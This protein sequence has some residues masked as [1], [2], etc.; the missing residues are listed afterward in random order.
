[1]K[2]DDLIKRATPKSEALLIVPGMDF[3]A[4]VPIEH[5]ELSISDFDW[6]S[7]LKYYGAPLKGVI[8]GD[9]KK[10]YKKGYVVRPLHE[11]KNFKNSAI[12]VVHEKDM[13]C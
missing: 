5:F 10:V 7:M 4:G 9:F 13:I 1:M 11:Y 8:M 6:N 3:W 12:Y 2:K